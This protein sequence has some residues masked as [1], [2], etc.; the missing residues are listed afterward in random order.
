MRFFSPSAP[1]GAGA[2]GESVAQP[3]QWTTCFSPKELCSKLG[4]PHSALRKGAVHEYKKPLTDLQPKSVQNLVAATTPV[5]RAVLTAY[6]TDWMGVLKLIASSLKDGKTVASAQREQQ[7]TLLKATPMFQATVRAYNEAPSTEHRMTVLSLLVQGLTLE[8]VQ[9]LELQPHVS[10][11]L[12]WRARNH[13]LEHG[14][15]LPAPQRQIRRNRWNEASL[16]DAVAFIFQPSIIQYL[17]YGAKTY[18]LSDGSMVTV[19]KID[20]H[21]IPEKIWQQYNAKCT[22]EDGTYHGMKRTSFMELLH[23]CTSSNCK[24]MAALDNDA[25]R[26]MENFSAMRQ[27][28]QDLAVRSPLTINEAWQKSLVEKIDQVG[29][30]FAHTCAVHHV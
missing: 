29:G 8:E 23:T 10:K 28:V 15:G 16:K 22:G 14:P 26:G 17:A 25:V 1:S 11:D 20:R 21:V 7:L 18:D 24:S 5:L 2:N 4:I 27:F 9:G 30:C 3:Q 19:P 12:F 13:A 6:H